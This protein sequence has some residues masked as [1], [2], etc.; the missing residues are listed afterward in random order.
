MDA[1]TRIQYE[2]NTHY[3]ASVDRPLDYFKESSLRK[4]SSLDIV[5]QG[6]KFKSSYAQMALYKQD[7]LDFNCR[8]QV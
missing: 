8:M 6:L 4:R 1:T 2:L 3:C 5:A 7:F